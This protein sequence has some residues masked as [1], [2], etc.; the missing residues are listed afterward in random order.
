[1]VSM[2]VFGRPDGPLEL[3]PA[4]QRARTVVDAERAAYTELTE[5][6]F[7]LLPGQ[8]GNP[9]HHPGGVTPLI[10]MEAAG[11]PVATLLGWEL[12]ELVWIKAGERG[13]IDGRVPHWCVYP[14]V[15]RGGLLLPRWL[16][17]PARGSETRNAQT[18]R[19]DTVALPELWPIARQRVAE[20]GWDV[21]F[22]AYAP[23]T[24]RSA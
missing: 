3:T 5:F 16:Q 15:R 6:D 10:R 1:V 9:H 22:S 21:D 13:V 11:G 19:E 17:R 23:V 12:E 7:E 4:G 8:T 18:V 14:R 2:D 20:Y 24:E